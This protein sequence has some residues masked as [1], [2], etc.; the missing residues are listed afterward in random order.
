MRHLCVS[1]AASGPACYWRGQRQDSS[2]RSRGR[3]PNTTVS[4]LKL[5]QLSVLEH[6]IC[7]S[8]LPFFK[9]CSDLCSWET[10]RVESGS[11]RRGVGAEACYTGLAVPFVVWGRWH[12]LWAVTP[13]SYHLFSDLRGQVIFQSLSELTFR[14]SGVKTS[15]QTFSQTLGQLLQASRVRGAER[16]I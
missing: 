4:L 11:A 3:A 7:Y 6:C 15:T 8:S 14:M 5:L 1:A 13:S 12:L 16:V 9:L 2:F 10:M